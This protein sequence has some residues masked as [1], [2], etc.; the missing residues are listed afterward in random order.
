MRQPTKEE[1]EKIT[2]PLMLHY[3]G[4]DTRVNEGW[5]VFEEVLKKK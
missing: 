1:A 2:T 4:L 5:P 3:A